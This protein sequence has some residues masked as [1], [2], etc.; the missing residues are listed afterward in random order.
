MRFFYRII[1]LVIHIA[2]KPS[3]GLLAV[4]L[5]MLLGESHHQGYYQGGEIFH[6]FTEVRVLSLS[7]MQRPALR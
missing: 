4:S 5:L 7:K 6:I 1:D 2:H 3:K